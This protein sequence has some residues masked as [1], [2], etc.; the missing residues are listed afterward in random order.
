MCVC[1]RARKTSRVC[2][3]ALLLCPRECAAEA[4]AALRPV[5]GRYYL[6]DPR[7]VATAMWTSFRECY[8]LPAAAGPGGGVYFTHAGA[9]QHVA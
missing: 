4:T 9:R 3:R 7:P 2:A 5:L 1:V 6:T 8:G